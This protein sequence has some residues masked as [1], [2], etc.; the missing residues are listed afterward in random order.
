MIGLLLSLPLANFLVGCATI[1]YING[2]YIESIDLPT[3]G[4]DEAKKVLDGFNAKV[5]G[6]I[7]R[8]GKGYRPIRIREGE[9][10]NFDP[11]KVTVG[12]AMPLPNGCQITL[13]P[14][15]IYDS[16]D[17]REVLLH[18]YL[19]CFNYGHNEKDRNDL[20]YPTTGGNVSEENITHYAKELKKKLYGRTE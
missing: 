5:G 1:V 20:M 17:F 12:Q 13:N 4:N 19:H 15:H 14:K 6:G 3:L 18:E 7:V 16:K 8:Y 9:P 10:I 2:S 11:D